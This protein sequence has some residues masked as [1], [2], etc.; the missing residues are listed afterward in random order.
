MHMSHTIELGSRKREH[1][2]EL[3]QPGDTQLGEHRRHIQEVFDM[4]RRDFG[5]GLCSAAVGA[6]LARLAVAR[7][8]TTRV[9]R[10]VAFILLFSSASA[11]A[12]DACERLTAAKL[13]NTMVT[14]AQTVA[15]GTLN[16]PPPPP[17]CRRQRCPL[18][19]SLPP[20]R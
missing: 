20:V 8:P 16:R 12:Q 1:C 5:Q 11:Y 2:V 14:L 13:T 7:Q 15:A 18:Y 19:Y 4:N 3:V 9:A 6:A 17:S 10:A